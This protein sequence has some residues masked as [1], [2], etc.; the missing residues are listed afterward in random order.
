[1][2]RLAQR[3]LMTRTAAF[4]AP[5]HNLPEAFEFFESKVVDKDIHANYENLETLRLTLTRQDEFLLK[6][7]HVK[8]V[9]IAGVNGES[10]IYPGHAYEIVQLSPSPITVE[11]ADGTVHKYF[12]SGGFAHINNEGSC[13][14]NC[15][16]CVPLAELD[17]EAAEKALAEQNNLLGQAKDEKAKSVVEIRVS[18]LEAVIQTL[19]HN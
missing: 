8:C 16:E 14:I 12:T 2:F 15:V 6:E 4:F 9:T 3:R 5:A 1:M 18:V 10:G 19:K 13:D 17:L 7:H 11:H